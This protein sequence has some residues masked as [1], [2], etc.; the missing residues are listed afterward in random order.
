MT[1]ET[2]VR[3]DAVARTFGSGAGA[4]AAVRD[5]T[6]AIDPGER[7][8]LV[9]PSGSGKSTLVQLIANLD[10][11]STGTITWPALGDPSLLRPGPIAVAFQGLSLLP[12]LTV[13]ENVAL[14]ATLAGA[15]RSEAQA[16][17]RTLM[18]AC[19]LDGLEDKLPE[20]LSG[21]QAQRA[22][23]ARA[24]CGAP[25]LLLA[26]EPTGQQDRAT[27]DHVVDAMLA[28]ADIGRVTLVIATHDERIAERLAS[29]W[30]MGDG[31]LQA[32]EPACSA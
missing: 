17:A 21:G 1:D 5:A 31:R 15:E 19:M 6:F 24:F 22:A 13:L 28:L 23:I 8:A 18:D 20:E 10:R 3:A 29:R 4:V 27:A 7:I 26:D 25:R 32:E 12:P 2:L 30:V 11:P 9:G 14:A 16:S